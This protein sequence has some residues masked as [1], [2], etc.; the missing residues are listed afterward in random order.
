MDGLGIFQQTAEAVIALLSVLGNALVLYVIYR[1]K[2]LRTTTNYLI[3]SLSSADFLV[4]AEGIPCVIVNNLGLPPNFYGCL[5][6]N[7]LIVC[8]TQVSGVR[9]GGV[10]GF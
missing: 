10:S 8:M 6:M 9:K 2:S 5:F 7:C 3:A 1:Q 4:G